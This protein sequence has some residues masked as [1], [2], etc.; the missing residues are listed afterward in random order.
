MRAA[1]AV[2]ASLAAVPA[3]A[4]QLTSR[5]VTPNAPM[6]TAQIYT[7]CGGQN[8]SPE[9]SWTAPPAAAKSLVV[10]MIDRSVKPADWSHWIIVGLPPTT[11][12]L[13][14]NIGAVPP[15][16]QAIVTN[17][18]DAAYDGPCPPP[19]TGTHRYEITVWAMPAATFRIAG[20]ARAVDL[21]ARLERE[22]MDHATIVATA[23]R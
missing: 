11:R 21:L 13:P 3:A 2:I 7:R 1:V 20:D 14:R 5:D 16:G 8:I 22:S 6:P 4:M 12:S 10:T 17:F 15:A 18:G 19:G 23:G 9:L